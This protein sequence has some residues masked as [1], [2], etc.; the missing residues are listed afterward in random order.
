M[1]LPQSGRSYEVVNPRFG[2]VEKAK[3]SKDLNALFHQT[4]VEIFTLK[5]VEMDPV[6]PSGFGKGND[7]D[8]SWTKNVEIYWSPSSGVTLT[9][10]DPMTSAQFLTSIYVPKEK[11]PA[12]SEAI[13]EMRQLDL[14]SKSEAGAATI[15]GA[16][17]STKPST[18]KIEG[19][20]TPLAS[21][22]IQNIDNTASSLQSIENAS[23][24]IQKELSTLRESFLNHATEASER[25]LADLRNQLRNHV[26]L[27][28]STPVSV[29][30]F[31]L[32]PVQ[33]YK[34]IRLTDPNTKLAFKKRLLELTGH[35][36]PDP[37][38]YTARTLSDI[39]RALF[40]LAQPAPKRTAAKL[41]TAVFMYG[42]DKRVPSK[43][44]PSKLTTMQ[45]VTIHDRRIRQQER[46]RSNG[47]GKVIKYALAERD[48]LKKTDMSVRE[49]R[50]VARDRQRAV[51]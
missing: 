48:L 34:R 3:S 20:S 33:I 39:H 16:V 37:T 8:E 9:N 1:L 21:E 49:R 40:A 23:T 10:P 50:D 45:N 15:T 25:T 28:A 43:I 18:E 47:L 13:K 35:N 2:A 36:I 11:L 17:E 22:T 24:G 30:D 6:I 46:E 44:V 32:G 12:V 7:V 31:K 51:L 27:K 42:S 4:A 41:K 19:T 29:I 38:L 5:S 26:T 14:E